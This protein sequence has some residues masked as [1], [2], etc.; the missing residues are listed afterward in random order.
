MKK[1]H[2]SM[3]TNESYCVCPA[4]LPVSIRAGARFIVYCM[5]V[6]TICFNQNIT[7]LRFGLMT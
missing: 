3:R 5:C 7:L 2:G 4:K 6:V 1:H